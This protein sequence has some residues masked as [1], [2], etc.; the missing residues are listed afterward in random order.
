MKKLFRLQLA[1]LLILT[2]RSYP[3]VA[4]VAIVVHPD[5]TNA[6]DARQI[7]NIF[8]GKLKTFPDGESVLTYDLNVDDFNFNG[9]EKLGVELRQSKHTQHNHREEQQI[10]GIFMPREKF[11]CASKAHYCASKLDT[12][13]PAA[14]SLNCV[15]K[16]SWP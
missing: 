9:R 4:G 14:A 16:I 15:S 3:A 2:G 8:L 13:T 6:L 7:R 11:D 12:A 1:I 10:G 5:N